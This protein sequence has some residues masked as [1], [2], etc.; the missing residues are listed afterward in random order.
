[1][2]R[3]AGIPQEVVVRAREIL[4]Q[5]ERSEKREIESSR[6]PDVQMTL[7]TPLSQR[8]VDQIQSVDVNALTPDAGTEFVAGTAAGSSR[9]IAGDGNARMKTT[10]L[11]HR[12]G[13]LL[14]VGVE[15]TSLSAL[16]S[17]LAWQ[18][19]AERNHSVSPQ[20]GGA[21]RNCMRYGSKQRTCS[22]HHFFVASISK[23]ERS[24][25]CAIWWGRRL[26]RRRLRPPIGPQSSREAA[27]WSGECCMRWDS[28]WIW[29]RCWTWRCRL[30]RGDGNARGLCRSRKT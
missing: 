20:H 9:G 13:S 26:P 15:S 30:R 21:G 1:M 7:F 16:G 6:E 28:M 29:R 5:H 14:I 3:L 12:V 27:R 19:A 8:I 17:G 2:A 18:S 25:G 11:R 23:A 10:A 4:R 24:I 22:P